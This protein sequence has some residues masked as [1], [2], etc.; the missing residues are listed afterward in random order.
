[1]GTMATF[2]IRRN[3]TVLTTPAGEVWLG[4]FDS[5]PAHVAAFSLDALAPPARR[6]RPDE[7]TI[8]AHAGAN[9]TAQ[10]VPQPG[11]MLNLWDGYTWVP[12]SCNTSDEATPDSVSVVTRDPYVMTPMQVRNALRFAIGPIAKHGSGPL[13]TVTTDYVELRVRYHLGE[14]GAITPEP[15]SG[16]ESS[17]DCPDAP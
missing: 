5:K 13:A 8:V 2:D 10:D 9:S 7:V 3:R 12:A 14:S 16:W 17:G 6:I 11:A 15:E 4:D 1:M